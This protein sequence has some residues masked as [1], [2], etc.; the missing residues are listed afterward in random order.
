MY[1]ILDW[2]VQVVRLEPR[3]RVEN[4]SRVV[5]VPS[6]CPGYQAGQDSG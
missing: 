6:C 2:T 3:V 1:S 5:L 4:I